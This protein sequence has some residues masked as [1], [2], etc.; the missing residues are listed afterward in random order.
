[1]DNKNILIQFR[2][3]VRSPSYDYCVEKL[4]KFPIYST[5]LHSSYKIILAMY[6]LFICVTQDG[7]MEIF[8]AFEVEF[9]N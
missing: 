5:I 3:H 7:W 9:F 6:S 2:M 4:G 8:E 1:V